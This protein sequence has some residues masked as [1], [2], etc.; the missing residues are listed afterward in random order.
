[1]T[2]NKTDVLVIGA[3]NAGLI[4]ALAAHEQGARVTVIEWAPKE[5]RGGNSAFA[6]GFFRCAFQDFEEIRPFLHPTPTL[7][8]DQIEVEPYTPDAFNNDLMRVTEGLA[9]TKLAEMLVEQSLPTVTWMASKGII[10]ELDPGHAVQ[11]NGRYFFRSASVPVA[12]KGGGKGLM[13]MLFA[14][15]ER[16]GL[17]ILY[18]ARAVELLVDRAGAVEG[19]ELST[20]QGRIAFHS[21]AV[22]LAC[23]GFEANAEMRARYLG[24][25]W[26]LV[27]VRG[28]RY[29]TGDGIKMALDIGAMP[30]GHWSGCHAS[31]IDADAADLEADNADVTRYSFPLSIMV[32]QDGERFVDEGEDLSSFTYAKMGRK[33]LDQP[34][35]IAYQIFDQKTLRFLRGPYSN[36]RAVVARSIEELAES[37]GISSQILIRTV[38]EF[39]AAVSEG[40]FDPSRRDGK[41]TRGISPG[42]SNWA[43]PLDSP[44]FYAYAVTCGITFTYGGLRI[45]QECRVLTADERPIPNLWAAGEATGGF[46]YHNYP[47]ASGLTRG[48]VTGRLAG[49]SAA[50]SAKGRTM[51]Q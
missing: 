45:D 23:G 21:Q 50:L 35:S 14:S 1:M 6:A 10:W 38:E 47:G 46:F 42:K 36:S 26:D 20:P 28:T 32:N 40:E 34:G 31:M 3:G 5:R 8:F 33:V 11:R 13:D 18:D 22:I 48:A 27:K 19:V 24:P 41:C 29:N 17:E 7:P 39:N 2:E 4:A 15:A 16:E 9:D 51:G 30:S 49:L 12:A 43:L 44:P 37:L 25:G